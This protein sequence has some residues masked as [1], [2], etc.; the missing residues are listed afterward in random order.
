MRVRNSSGADRG[1]AHAPVVRLVCGEEL[2]QGSVVFG[3]PDL[4]P[5]ALHDRCVL[6]GSGCRA[7]VG[8]FRRGIL[9]QRRA[10]GTEGGR[11]DE[12]ANGGLR[13]GAA[14]DV[15][16]DGHRSISC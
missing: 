2:G 12:D 9:R 1:I 16:I 6:V 14:R 13:K 10:A 8:C 4:V 15:E 11:A 7:G 5:I 3:V